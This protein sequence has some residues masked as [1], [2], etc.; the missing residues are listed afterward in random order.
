M[1]KNKSNLPEGVFT[2]TSGSNWDLDGF[3]FD[4]E[5]SGE[6]VLQGGRLPSAQGFSGLPGN[7]LS[8]SGKFDNAPIGP[9][10]VRAEQDPGITNWYSEDDGLDLRSF[11][12]AD[13]HESRLPNLNWLELQTDLEKQDPNRLPRDPSN[14]SIEELSQAWGIDRRTHGIRTEGPKMRLEGSNVDLNHARYFAN[15]DK[16]VERPQRFSMNQIQSV[17]QQA[18]RR[19]ASGDP[20]RNI[21]IETA[22]ILG[23]SSN[24][25]A[26][27][28]K[29]IVEEHGLAGKVFLRAS[30]YPGCEQGTWKDQV[31]QSAQYVVA[32]SKC[33]GCVFNQNSVCGMFQRRLVASVPWE[34]AYLHY[35]PR[36][37][38]LGVKVATE[39]DPK[40]VLRQAF[41]TPGRIATPERD[42]P[43]DQSHKYFRIDELM[44]EAKAD[45][46]VIAVAALRAREGDQMAQKVA[47][48]LG[49]CVRA[50]YLTKDQA[51]ALG[52]TKLQLP[53]IQN[54]VSL[55]ISQQQSKKGEFEGDVFS[56]FTGE[57]QFAP[58]LDPW[59]QELKRV[60]NAAG[61]KVAE[62]SG[63]LRRLRLRLN[64]GWA[65]NRLD[66]LMR[67]EFSGNILTAAAHLIHA[68]RYQHEGLAGHL[69]IEAAAYG[70]EGI[71]GCE[72][73][74]KHH[75][76]S[77][78]PYVLAM[79]KCSGCLFR[80]MHNTCTKYNKPLAGGFPENDRRAFQAQTITA[81]NNQYTHDNIPTHTA[82]NHA[83]VVDPAAE[84]GLVNANLDNINFYSESP[85]TEDLD[86]QFD[87]GLI[88]F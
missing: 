45:E 50:G 42:F 57:Q 15:L 70:E 73:G 19:S 86:I 41:A 61:V 23:E 1:A 52:Q 3:L 79:D 37:S 24:R 9:R 76:K 85:D 48:Y 63:M 74:A 54:M 58:Q 22:Q 83:P 51:V 20:I 67:S 80:N 77:A 60:A 72:A 12:A 71:Q 65:G 39:G 75:A 44:R 7:N 78:A 59:Q 29:S 32:S 6:G 40:E 17:V 53:V 69:Y 47:T 16:D 33:V 64:D 14:L 18:A 36:L 35:A 49:Q 55:Y 88:L 10:T 31:P 62:V 4:G 25:V 68:M 38:S 13:I 28:M 27:A 66:G 43:V 21:L 46:A 81:S 2:S 30:V 8:E 56:E 5:G 34:E 11:L 84:F 87:D 26:S 82:S